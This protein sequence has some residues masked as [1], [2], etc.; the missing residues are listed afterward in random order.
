MLCLEYMNK[1]LMKF[2]RDRSQLLLKV[3]FVLS[4]NKNMLPCV[5]NVVQILKLEASLNL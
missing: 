1:K 3:Y 4:S 5:Y 2:F